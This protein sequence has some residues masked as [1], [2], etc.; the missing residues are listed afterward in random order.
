MIRIELALP[1]SNSL[2]QLNCPKCGTR[3]R[4]FGI[5]ADDP[6]QEL[7]SFDCPRCEHIETKVRKSNRQRSA[8][9]H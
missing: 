8:L 3:M 1:A 6:G 4:L 5:E 7:L 9:L 2:K